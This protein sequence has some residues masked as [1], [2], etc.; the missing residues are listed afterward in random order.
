[1]FAR[2]FLKSERGTAFVFFAIT[3]PVLMGLALLVIDV[4]RGNNVGSDVQKNADA[5]ALAAARE[6]DGATD[7]ITRANNAVTAYVRNQVRFAG[8]GSFIVNATGSAAGQITI[9][10]LD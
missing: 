8:N 7:A 9:Y 10:Y 5:L 3:L 6:L 1:M 2:R 4:G